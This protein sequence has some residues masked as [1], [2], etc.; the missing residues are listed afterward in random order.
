MTQTRVEPEFAQM[1]ERIF[2]VTGLRTQVE[3]AG[4]LSIRQSSISDAQR[5]GKIPSNWLITLMRVKNVFP[6]WVL[7]GSGPCTVPNTSSGYETGQE[8]AE[9]Q[10]EEESLQKL[11]SRALAEELIR[12]IAVSQGKE[13]CSD[14]NG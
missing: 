7:T 12:R 1:L 2:L 9:R 14:G 11:S 13:F 4:F 5:R 6:E 8:L 3:L 10:T